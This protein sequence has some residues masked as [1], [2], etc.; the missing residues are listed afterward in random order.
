MFVL[1]LDRGRRLGDFE[2]GRGDSGDR[3]ARKRTR[4]GEHGAVLDAV[5]SEFGEC[6]RR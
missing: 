6:R 4:L 5:P 2:A 1:D 3:L